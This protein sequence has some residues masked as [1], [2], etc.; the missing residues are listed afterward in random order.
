MAIYKFKERI[1]TKSGR[2]FHKSGRRETELKRLPLKLVE[3]TCMI[4]KSI[5]TN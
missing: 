1:L 5:K 4:N 2:F 3:L